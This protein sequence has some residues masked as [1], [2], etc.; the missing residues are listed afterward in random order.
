M[1]SRL[2]STTTTTLSWS[3]TGGAGI[4]VHREEEV[5]VG[6][7]TYRPPDENPW[8]SIAKAETRHPGLVRCGSNIC[9]GCA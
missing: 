8:R 4:L 2:S 5:E 9:D 6:G 1:P 3:E 7:K